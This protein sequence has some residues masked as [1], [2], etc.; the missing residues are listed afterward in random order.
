ML[1]LLAVTALVAGV[2]YLGPLLL[3]VVWLAFCAWI[4]Y[5]IFAGWGAL[6]GF[7]FGW[8]IWRRQ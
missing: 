3:V 1:A 2:W 5:A 6:A 8:M 7:L 4:G